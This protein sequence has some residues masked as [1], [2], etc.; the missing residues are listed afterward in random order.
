VPAAAT[1]KVP[2]PAAISACDCWFSLI[3]ASG[4]ARLLEN[5]KPS[6][7]MAR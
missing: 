5:V 1:S 7:M 3:E 2:M 4:L 6:A